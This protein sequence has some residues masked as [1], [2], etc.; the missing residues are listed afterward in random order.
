MA[1]HNAHARAAAGEYLVTALAVTPVGG[2]GEVDAVHGFDVR[3]EVRSPDARPPV[4]AVGVV[5]ADGTPVY[6]TTSEVDRAA[7]ERIASDLF[8]FSVRFSAL[9]LLPGHYRVRA[10]AVDPEG[11]RVFDHH[12][13]PVVVAGA[14]RE[15]GFCRL[16][17][18]WSAA[19]RSGVQ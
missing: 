13:A 11:M 15:L 6:G 8:A 9:P 4:V 17:H 5:R 2:G 14:S 12:E 1:K 16:P 7:P 18:A 19:P 3:I 10:H